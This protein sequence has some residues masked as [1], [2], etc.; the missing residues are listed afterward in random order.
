MPARIEDVAQR[1]GLSV[2]TVSRVMNN[3]KNVSASARERVMRA[4]DELNY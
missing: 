1:C 4:I 2:A 3:G